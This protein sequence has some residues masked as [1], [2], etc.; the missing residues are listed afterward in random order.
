MVAEAVDIRRELH[1]VFRTG[2]V[3]TI[4]PMHD[5]SIAARTEELR[6]EIALIQQAENS[7]SSRKN[8]SLTENAEHNK[9]EFRILAIREELRTFVEKAKEQF[10]HGTV[11][12]S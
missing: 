9:R 7:Y 4:G 6:R 1:E 12:Y 5:T 3:R 2:P 11:W 10:N 8:H